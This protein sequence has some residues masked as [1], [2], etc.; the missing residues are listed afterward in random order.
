LTDDEAVYRISRLFPGYGLIR[1]FRLQEVPGFRD[2]NRRRRYRKRLFKNA[3]SSTG[4]T[5]FEFNAGIF[6]WS[7]EKQR[8]SAERFP[9]RSSG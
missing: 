2:G 6:P 5:E 7:R 8:F 4:R 3:L 9:A 1:E